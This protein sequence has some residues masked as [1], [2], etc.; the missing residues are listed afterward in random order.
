MLKLPPKMRGPAKRAAQVSMALTCD[1][2]WLAS[3]GRWVVK[4]F[5]TMLFTDTLIC[6]AERFVS[7]QD[8]IPGRW[9][10]D[11]N[12]DRRQHGQRCQNQVSFRRRWLADQWLIIAVQLPM[13]QSLALVS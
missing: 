8:G 6:A 11:R 2:R 12:I 4:T 7:N 10:V 3:R 9:S 5:T 13:G 1:R